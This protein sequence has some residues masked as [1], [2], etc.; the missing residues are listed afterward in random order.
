M[1]GKPSFGISESDSIRFAYP[2]EPEWSEVMR[3][4][5]IDLARN[6]GD[7]LSC[8]EAA[9][10]ELYRRK[11]PVSVEICEAILSPDFEGADKWFKASAMSKLYG[12]SL[13]TALKFSRE[14]LPSCELPVLLEI[15]DGL[16]FSR[17]RAIQDKE[18]AAV[19]ALALARLEAEKL[20]EEPMGSQAEVVGLFIERFGKVQ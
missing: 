19:A 20:N 11:D 5:L 16:N 9:L 6:C 17:P 1:Q 8:A 10:M 18:V 3:E 2:D 12:R 7:E 15:I 4:T 14:V 13:M